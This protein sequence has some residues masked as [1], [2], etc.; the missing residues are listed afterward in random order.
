MFMIKAQ[1]VLTMLLFWNYCDKWFYYCFMVT[2][3]LCTQ[4]SPLC[5]LYQVSALLVAKTATCAA[6]IPSFL[7][8][9][10]FT[11]TS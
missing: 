1:H 7:L 5:H 10:T 3:K 2:F 9:I 6:R 4:C 8:P 11:Q